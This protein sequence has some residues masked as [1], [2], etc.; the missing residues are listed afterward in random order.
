MSKAYE[1]IMA[2]LQ[3]ALAHARGEETGAIIHHVEIENIDVRALRKQLKMSRPQFA[4]IFG[5]K[6]G[7][8]RNWEQGRRYPEGPARV[9]LQVISR[10]PEAV[11]RALAQ[12]HNPNS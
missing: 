11:I 9:L 8:V 5:M 10:E 1:E 7:T 3:D 12:D 6:L 4:A 2:G